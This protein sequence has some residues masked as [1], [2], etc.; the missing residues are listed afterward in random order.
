MFL[1]N[2]VEPANGRVTNTGKSKCKT[3][4]I[5][6]VHDNIEI[7]SIFFSFSLFPVTPTYFHI[8]LSC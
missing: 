5:H 3:E 4:N 7:I 1:I 6:L 8:S 2:V